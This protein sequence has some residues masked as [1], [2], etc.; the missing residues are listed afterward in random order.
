MKYSQKR[1]V[2]YSLAE[3]NLNKQINELKQNLQIKEQELQKWE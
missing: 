1:L 3:E 2:D